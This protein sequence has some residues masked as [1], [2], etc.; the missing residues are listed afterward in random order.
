MFR[1]DLI[2]VLVVFG[3]TVCGT[4]SSTVVK[5][6]FSHSGF[7]DGAIVT[8]MFEGEDLNDDGFLVGNEGPAGSNE[9]TDFNMAFSGNSI[10]PAFALGFD[11]FEFLAYRLD[12]GPLGDSSNELIAA[13]SD[14][15]AGLYIPQGFSSGTDV[16]DECKNSYC[17]F[18]FVPGVKFEPNYSFELVT[19]NAV[20]L[21][22][23]IWLFGSGLFGLIGI[24]PIKSFYKTILT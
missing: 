17:A 14:S 18:V 11:E 4:A 22:A 20:P 10:V 23:A 6:N 19:V 21:P 7:A 9:I 16:P 8:G 1:N 24:R 3:I 5:Y 2:S 12:G 13:L 15:D